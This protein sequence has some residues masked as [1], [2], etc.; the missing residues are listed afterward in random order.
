MFLKAG[1]DL[2]AH[3]GVVVASFNCASVHSAR[4]A[5]M[6]TGDVQAKVGLQFQ[7]ED[8]TKAQV[9]QGEGHV[10]LHLPEKNEKNQ[11]KEKE[12][13]LE[14][15]EVSSRNQMRTRPFVSHSEPPAI[16]AGFHLQFLFFINATKTDERRVQIE[17]FSG[18]RS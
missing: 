8:G 2:A 14:Q 16:G 12:A 4:F 9:S 13:T 10:F 7:F 1:D 17:H 6:A 5:C 15:Q 18:G 3:S 11:S